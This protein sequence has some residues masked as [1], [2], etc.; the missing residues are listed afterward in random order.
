[1]KVDIID[2]L[3]EAFIMEAVNLY[4]HAL[5]DKLLP[6]LG[7][8]KR[9]CRIMAGHVDRGHC[10]SAWVNRKLAGILAVQSNRQSFWNPTL[11]SM[12]GAYG[13]VEGVFRFLGLLFLHHRTRP[14]EWII[15]G[16]AVK[17]GMRGLGI[18]SALI[19]R[20]EATALTGG[21]RT[22]SLEVADFNHKA[23]A[24]YERLGFI[25]AGQQS[26]RPFNQIYRFPFQTSTTMLK[27]I[28]NQEERAWERRKIRKKPGLS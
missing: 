8:E 6:V 25:E 11:R 9:A 22:V 12:T 15:D 28:T 14:G 21:A 13:P 23:R 2:H 17:E 24:L 16:V 1:M 20:F 7:D 26:L 27:T 3:P 18:G 4:V 10:L 19:R 5:K